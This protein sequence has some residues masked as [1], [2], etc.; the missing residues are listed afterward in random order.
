METNL[1]LTTSEQDY[2]KT[3]YEQTLSSERTTTMALAERLKV[4]PPSVTGMLQKLAGAQP[5]LVD[6]S[7]H[8]GAMLTEAGR[9]AALAVLRRHR[10]LETFL[11]TVMGYTWDE[12]HIEAER[13][14]H[15][16]SPRFEQRM[17]D[18]LGDP[19]FDPHG[20]PIPAEDLAMPDRQLVSLTSLPAGQQ[21][22]VRHV[23]TMDGALL[24]HLE[25][26]GLTPGSRLEVTARSEFDG[27]IHVR[28]GSSS[29]PKVLGVLLTDLVWVDSDS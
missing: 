14:E 1:S 4:A 16:I 8:R 26:L 5:P 27:V 28:S 17:A 15:V 20:D 25:S 7:K 12:V 9:Q 10:L 3:I 11:V 24:R 6:Y 23:R 19:Q 13:L 22:T 2:L 29:T 18:M 21:A